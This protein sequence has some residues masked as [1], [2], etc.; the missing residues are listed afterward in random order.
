V[1]ELR[2][3]AAEAARN[4]PL[5]AVAVGCDHLGLE[6]KLVLMDHLAAVGVAVQDF[7]CHTSSEVD[8]PD[9]AAAVARAVAA[10]DF[11]RA[12]LVCGTGLGMAITANKVPG[13]RAAPVTDVYSAERARKSN[14]AQVLC[15]GALV[16]GAGLATSLVD[17]WLES[18]FSGGRSAGKVA[19]INAVERAALE[20]TP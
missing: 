8:Y 13:V 2:P 19:K 11:D 9:I 12:I 14:D 5:R 10:G 7:G 17:H 15:L 16:V 20:G 3:A 18:E 1:T 4:T 6:L